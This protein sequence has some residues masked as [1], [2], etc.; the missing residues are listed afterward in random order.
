MRIIVAMVSPYVPIK[1][2][3][4]LDTASHS[5]VSLVRPS[6][7]SYLQLFYSPIPSQSG[8]DVAPR[9]Q[10]SRQVRPKK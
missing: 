7:I 2:H 3:F 10:V 1:P 4:A 8:L 6:F 5:D 9:L